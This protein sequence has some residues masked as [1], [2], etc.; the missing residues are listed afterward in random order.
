MVKRLSSNELN[1]P[2]AKSSDSRG[3]RPATNSSVSRGYLDFSWD[4]TRADVSLKIG[5]CLTKMA[6]AVVICYC[7]GFR[8]W[9]RR[10]RGMMVLFAE[11]VWQ[12]E[13]KG[14]GLSQGKVGSGST[15]PVL[16]HNQERERR[17]GTGTGTGTGRW[18]GKTPEW[19]SGPLSDPPLHN[20]TVKSDLGGLSAFQIVWM[21]A[22][23][24]AVRIP[25]LRRDGSQ[26]GESMKTRADEHE[27]QRKRRTKTMAED[28]IPT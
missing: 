3:P 4:T 10:R 8:S 13:E 19:L 25:G 17:P 6:V 2:A 22:C 14:A 5:R 16:R 7:C 1:P 21:L 11:D 9:V 20:S 28:G 26:I 15:S 27:S 23:C 12:R 24:S 18:D